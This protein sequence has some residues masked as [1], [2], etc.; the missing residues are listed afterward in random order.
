[1]TRA[2]AMQ[3]FSLVEV[4]VAATMIGM[5]LFG[6]SGILTGYTKAKT[7]TN[8]L[9]VAQNIVQAE[10]DSILMAQQI[11][12]SL[13]S[14]TKGRARPIYIE[15]LD[16]LVSSYYFFNFPDFSANKDHNSQGTLW[17]DDNTPGRF[18]NA[19]GVLY[20]AGGQRL[21]IQLG[22]ANG[23]ALENMPQVAYIA[24]V[25]LFGANQEPPDVEQYINGQISAANPNGEYLDTTE[26]PDYLVA[27]TCDSETGESANFPGLPYRQKIVVVR[28]YPRQTYLTP[29]VDSGNYT[30]VNP[31]GGAKRELAHGYAVINGKIRL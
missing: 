8:G 10:L 31:G 23:D 19:P 6:M 30:F 18:A 11:E 22:M 1:M 26:Q 16:L 24:R 13:V 25:Q 21:N 14:D 3:G 29:Q 27:D 2:R 17:D 15:R 5:T 9:A 20:D 28:V 12:N 4:M 7:G